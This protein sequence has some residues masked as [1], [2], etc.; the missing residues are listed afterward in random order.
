MS[1]DKLTN[2]LEIAISKIKPP[3]GSK[4]KYSPVRTSV[5][6]YKGSLV[7]FNE[8]QKEFKYW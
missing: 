1:D 6:K 2:S 3:A 7:I 8:E 5:K 4:N